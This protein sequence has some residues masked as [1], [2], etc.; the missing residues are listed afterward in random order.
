MRIGGNE[1]ENRNR[2]G[3]GVKARRE[4]GDVEAGSQMPGSRTEAGTPWRVGRFAAF[5]ALWIFGGMVCL[6]AIGWAQEAT[7]AASAKDVRELREM[8]RQLAARDTKLEAEVAELRAELHPM[9]AV[10][11]ATN[12]ARGVGGPMAP[13]EAAFEKASPM[14]GG[15]AGPATQQNAAVSASPAS[16]LTETDRGILDYLRGNTV[17][18]MFDG[19]YGYNFNAPVGR[20]NLVRGYDVLSNTFS[21]NQADVVFDHPTNVAEGHRF[22]MRMDLQF[23]QAT[24]TLQGNPANEPRP[25]IYRNIFQVYGTY[26]VP[27]GR[28]LTVDFGKWG[29]S[30][31]IEGNYTKDQ[32]NY[33]RS[34]WFSA[35]PFYHMGVRANLPLTSKLAVN[36]W[37]VNGTQQTEPTNGFKD[38]MFGVVVTPR[39]NVTWTVNYYL[40]QEHPDVLQVPNTTAI[41]TQPGLNFVA[42]RPAPDGRLHIFDSYVSWQTTPKLTLA[43]EGD[44]EIQRLWRNAAAGHSSAPSEIA[45]TAGYAQYQLSSHWALGA[46]AEYLSDPQG[47]FSGVSQALK[48]T[49]ATVDYKVAEGFLMR[50]EW[51]RDFSNQAYFLTSTQGVRSEQQNTATVGL[52]WWFGRKQGAW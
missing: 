5:R 52:M 22:G 31:G 7:V 43:L 2:R 45:G 13:T 47:M 24:A 40:G 16:A 28:G 25:D 18:V 20:V 6:S 36:Y 11:T 15:I 35:L 41:P 3:R 19:Y 29:S 27:V 4:R 26:V 33:S 8:V 1:S 50:Y 48:E 46:R 38:E 32:I 9:P 34:L 12:E 23:G 10:M 51:R 39:K 21:I 42:I 17:N 37:V 30:L 44:Y 49:T 14:T